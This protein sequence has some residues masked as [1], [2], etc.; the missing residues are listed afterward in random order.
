MPKIAETKFKIG[1]RVRIVSGDIPGRGERIGKE[2]T[3]EDRDDDWRNEASW[4]GKESSP[5]RF[6][7]SELELAHKF[8][9]GDKVRF[10][11]KVQATWYF[12][13]DTPY[14]TA[15][16]TSVR[17]TGGFTYEASVIGEGSFNGYNCFV[18]DEHIELIE[19]PKQQ[20]TLKEG[21]ILF[22]ITQLTSQPRVENL[23]FNS[24]KEALKWG[25]RYFVGH[26]TGRYKVIKIEYEA[27][28]K[29]A[30][31]DGDTI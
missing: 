9:V 27:P 13:P 20:V 21:F 12:G 15:T 16:I 10:T 30:V 1:D 28:V 3:I 29:V 6:R 8:K 24:E 7:D 17:P 19:E 2:F 14:M 18:N 31:D 25:A 23:V 22:F 26:N 4:S 11:D 5:W